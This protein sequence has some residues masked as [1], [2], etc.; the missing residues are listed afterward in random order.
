MYTMDD[1]CA[2]VLERSREICRGGVSP[3]AGLPQTFS[4]FHGPGNPAP[5]NFFKKVLTFLCGYVI[6]RL[7]PQ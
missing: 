6:I 4:F 2:N 7:Y 1:L 5:Y 3:P